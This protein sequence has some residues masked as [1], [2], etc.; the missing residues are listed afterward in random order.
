MSKLSQITIPVL[1]ETTG[2]VTD[3]TFDIGGGDFDPTITSPADG[4]IL[5]YDAALGAWVNGGLASV[6]NETLTIG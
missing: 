6:A 3:Q 5:K 1:N 4:Q 2:V